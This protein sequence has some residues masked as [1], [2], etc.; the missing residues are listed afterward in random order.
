MKLGLLAAALAVAAI[1]SAGSAA[2]R[3]LPDGG[4]TRQE[5][6]DWLQTH[7][8][9]ARIKYDEVGKDY[10]VTTSVEGVNWDI[11]FYNCTTPNAGR[12][13][14]LQY[15]AGWTERQGMDDAKINVWNREHRYLRAYI[16]TSNGVFAE[17]D[18]GVSPGGTWEQLDASL[19]V[20]LLRLRDF[21]AYI[22]G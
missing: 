3:D 6:I 8:Y 19:A 11:W 15:A 2:A 4:L 13:R 12:C 20:W 7:G 16:T 1:G 22:G 5:V 10:A 21:K 18:V 17:Y 14:S 9:A